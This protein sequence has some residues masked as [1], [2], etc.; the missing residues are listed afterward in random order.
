M[1]AHLWLVGPQHRGREE[2]DIEVDCHRRLRGP[3][4]GLGS[5]LRTLVPTL[6][7]RWPELV[8]KHVIEILSIAPELEGS[9]DAAPE[10]LTSLAI[11]SEQTRIYPVNRTRRLTHGIIE[12][13]ESYAALAGLHPLALS[14]INVDEAD[15]TDQ[16]FL[17]IALRR[18]RTGQVKVIV[19]TRGDNVPEEL[20]SALDRYARLV[21]AS[22]T[23]DGDD[24]H[25]PEQLLQAYINSDGTSDDPAELVAYQGADPT[26]RAALH[27]R[28][29]AE[30]ED[31]GEWSLHLGAIPYH[32]EHGSDPANVGGTAILEAAHYCFFRGFY[33][34]QL[35]YGPRGRAVT[36]PD[37][38]I[39]Q[40]W[41]LSV[42]M[43]M[44]LA[45][46]GRSAEAEAIYLELRGRY[47][48][49]MLHMN[50]GYALAMLY[51]RLH[52]V[53]RRDHHLA[54]AY[55]KN[56]IT[57]ASLLPQPDE[58]TFNTVFL[59]NGLALVEM[60]LGNLAE[61]LR[62]VSEGLDR[63]D[64]E[65]PSDQH[66]LH[67]SVLV[68]NRGKVYAALGRLDE[69]LA[70]F[71]TVIELDPNYPDY[72]FDSADI[73]RKLGDSSGAA[74]DYERAF[75][76]T[77]P[78]YEL[79]YNRADL[80]AELGD[81]AGAVTDLSCV[82]ELEPDQLDARVNLV[83]LLLDTDEPAVAHVHVEEGLRLHPGDP[84]LLHAR[85][86]L[87]LETGDIERALKDFDLAL[88]AD[89]H[90]MPAL[91]SRAGL[92]HDVGD[93][94]AA[95]ADLTTA[96]E[97]DGDNPDLLYNRGYVHQAA[98]HWDAAV[99]DYT[100]AMELPGADRAELLQQRGRCHAELGD[101]A[102]HRADLAAAV[103]IGEHLQLA[104][105]P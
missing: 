13:L 61:S 9:I 60:H 79:H 31:R 44:A 12:L 35:D 52:P 72:Y 54:K 5:L 87:A 64:R 90:L 105:T 37:T 27:D 57:I 69:A 82:V 85:G 80:R 47:T 98:G 39:E 16:E 73:R 78:F 100:R 6:Y 41:F 14:F 66:R 104:G 45:V 30:L 74:I 56:S 89:A 36:D 96:L 58:R 86:L 50:T 59:E 48:D 49:P 81:L 84:R 76:L 43:T 97:V 19:G 23:P 22:P 33:H 62:L 28:R 8:R 63:L 53:D 103:E 20:A 3:Y 67:R 32:H 102:A 4:T 11:P 46:L 75:T 34:A 70:D 83:G 55:V 42:R 65:L 26:L 18:A 92:A 99:R 101:V 68:H 1:P 17:A 88:D 71:S 2:V 93:H 38:Q 29:A 40:Y 24:P 15:H 77:A 95:I 25:D 94:D 10:T 51:T 91:A 21:I 7:V